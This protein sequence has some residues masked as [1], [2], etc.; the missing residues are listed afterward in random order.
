MRRF[1]FL[2]GLVLG[3][4]GAILAQTSSAVELIGTVTANQVVNGLGFTLDG[5]QEWQWVAAAAAGATHARFQCP[6]V[7]VER[8]TPPPANA[9]ASPQ[10]VQT[11]D[12]V[13]SYM[14]ALKYHFQPTVVA[15]YGPPFHKILTLTIP[16]G[17]PAGA[18]SL[19]V[20]LSSSVAGATLANVRFPY[21]Y[22]Q[23]PPHE[24]PTYGKLSARGSYQGTLITGI[25]L[26][27]ATHATISLA[28]ALTA[29]LPAT[30]R[31]YTINEILYPSTATT[32]PTDPSVIAY[33]NYV[34]FLAKDMAARG[35]SGEIE[36]WNEPPWNPDPWDN[37]CNLYDPALH[38][39]CPA[40]PGPSGAGAP[41]YGF[42][43]N[44]QNRSFPP[45]ITLTWNG[46][47]GSG[48]ASLLS[49]QFHS[50]TGVYVNQPATVITKESFHPYGNTPEQVMFTTDCLRTTAAHFPRHPDGKF[51]NCYLPGQPKNSNIMAAVQFD[52]VAKR[53][54]QTQGI[55]HEITETGVL[56]PA[57]G[58]RIPQARFILR[59]YLGFEAEGITPI[60]F[61]KLYDA[62]AP[63]DPNFSFVEQVGKSSSYTPNPA[64]T[65]ISGLMADIKPISNVPAA[66]YPLSSLPSVVSYSGTYPLSA[67]HMVG[68]KQGSTHNSDLFAVW[69]RSFT[70]CDAKNTCPVWITQPSPA[71]GPL[72]VNI[73]GGM[74][75]ASVTNLTT[76]AIVPYTTSGQQ[77]SFSV[78]DDPVGI[79]V[80]P[81]G[82]RGGR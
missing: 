25:K 58:L 82:Q 8:Q 13:L 76:R 62:A 30:A 73:P 70:D 69:Q 54:D 32:S 78:A 74:K 4:F 52:M 37:R 45:G 26:A 43:A 79:L 40:T 28:S 48:E 7:S 16:G 44:L 59:Q 24:R 23:G 18:A 36:L 80:D 19:D 31:E 1:C 81:I 17:A 65:A 55:G 47:S 68:S 35:V 34:S 53:S 66:S 6:W 46:T 60:E 15:A 10:Y 57:P 42:A 21:D 20:V 39:P 50:Q 33:A 38:P 67:V 61:F 63:S 41:N 14:Y 9:P 51:M 56:P 3:C 29:A 72:T 27:D 12:C 75:V 22:I 77:I 5:T 71:P 64:Y 2:L 49:P 11:S